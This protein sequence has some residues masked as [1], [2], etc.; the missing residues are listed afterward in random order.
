M[1]VEEL[2]R[3]LDNYPDDMEIALMPS[4]GGRYYITGM[5]EGKDSDG[6]QVLEIFIDDEVDDDG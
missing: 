3:K 2:I 4:Y 5:E 6:N 1:T